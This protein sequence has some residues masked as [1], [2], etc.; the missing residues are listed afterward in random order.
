MSAFPVTPEVQQPQPQQNSAPDSSGA[1]TAV[2]ALAGSQPMPNLP[3]ATTPAPT[4]GKPSLWRAVVSGALSGLANSAGSKTFGE[5]LGRG[6]QGA[7]TDEQHQYALRTAAEQRGPDNIHAAIQ[8]D[9]ESQKA[10]LNNAV[11]QINLLKAHKELAL[12]PDSQRQQLLL[13]RISSNDGLIKA[14]ALQPASNEVGEYPDAMNMMSALHSSNPGAFYTVEPVRGDDGN[15]QYQVMSHPDSL[16]QAPIQLRAPDGSMQTIPAGSLTGKQVGQAQAAST[17]AM[18]KDKTAS[19]KSTI[20]KNY[21]DAAKASAA[22]SGKPDML[23]GSLPNGVQVAGTQDELTAAGIKN[24]IKLPS[25]EVGK[26]EIARSLISPGGLFD[27]VASDVAALNK[28]GK[29]GAASSRWNAILTN[30]LGSG[31]T[32]YARLS[33]DISLLQTAIQQAHVGSKGSDTLLEHFKQ[34]IG[35]PTISDAPTLL[36]RLGASWDYI[37]HKA[38]LLPK[39][40]K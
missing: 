22:K 25:G 37:H 14:G 36:A 39:G 17:L 5:G 13:Q 3:T 16:T 1:D 24:P 40:G 15:I 10:Q 8:T 4:E 19:V 7:L 32:D 35:D 34:T 33:T 2:A 20:T 27:N 23:V 11:A 21:A 30:K 26:V 9:N 12:L 38:M 29:L 18:L 31:D 6:A 28:S